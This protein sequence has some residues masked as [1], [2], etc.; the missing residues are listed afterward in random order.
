MEDFTIPR[1][2]NK[3]YNPS[4]GEDKKDEVKDF[5]CKHFREV[6]DGP[7][8]NKTDGPITKEN[9]SVIK[10]DDLNFKGHIRIQQRAVFSGKIL[11]FG[12]SLCK[13]NLT[14]SPNDLLKH[15]RAVHKGS[16]PTYPCDLCDFVTNE[17]PALQRHRIEHRNTLVT[18]ELCNDHVQYS[19][20]LLTRH[21]MMCHSINGE[22]KCDWCE[23]TTVDAG[24]FVQ[25]IHHHNESHWKCTI[26]RHISLNEEDHQSHIKAHSGTFTF[27]CQICGFGTAECEHLKKHT[28]TVHKEEAARK[29]A[30]KAVEDC[31][32]S[33]NSS[34][35][36][37]LYKK[38][39]VSQETQ[40]MSKL[41][42][43]PGTVSNENGR[44]TK[45]ELPLEEI[46]HL[47]DGTVGQRDNKSWSFHNEE[48]STPVMLQE[49]ENANNSDTGSN[50]STNGLTV[51]MVKNKI[52]LPPNCT[53][54]MMGFKIVDGKKHLV[55]KVIPTAKQDVS[56]QNH[57]LID[58]V[59]S[60]VSNP[61]VAK[62]IDFIEKKQYSECKGS[63]SKCL[64]ISPKNGSCIQMD[65]NDIMA[66][67][68]K[69]EEEETSVCT[70]NSIPHSEQTN[71]LQN[72]SYPVANNS[73]YSHFRSVSTEEG[74]VPNANNSDAG[75]F[76][77][78]GTN[79]GSKVTY[80]KTACEDTI[81]CQPPL[82]AAHKTLFPKTVFRETV[83]CKGATDEL[84]LSDGFGRLWKKCKGKSVTNTLYID[85]SCQI[86]LEN[87]DGTSIENRSKNGL[88]VVKH[89]KSPSQLS[90]NVSL[91]SR[92]DALGAGKCEPKTSNQEVFTFHNYSKEIFRSSPCN[93]QNPPCNREYSG[94]KEKSDSPENTTPI[95]DEEIE[96][97]ECIG[98]SDLLTEENGDSVIQD[99][100]IIKIE[101][102]GIPIS[103]KQTEAKTSLLSMES[104][105]KEH[106]NAII[107]QQLNKERTGFSNPS[108]AFLKQGEKSLNILQ[109]PCA[110]R[111]SLILKAA[112]KACPMPVQ[113]KATPNFK[114]ITSTP[115]SQIRLSKMKQELSNSSNITS[116]TVTPKAKIVG[117][118]ARNPQAT[119]NG[120]TVLSAVHSGGGT[121]SNHYIINS[122]GFKGPVLLSRTLH[123]TPT[124]TVVKAKPTCYFV[125]RSVPFVQNPS[126]S[127]FKL[128]GPQL[129]VISQPV[130]AGTFAEKASTPQTSRQAYLL[131]Y[132]SPSKSGLLENKQ[133][134]KNQT[135]WSQTSEYSGNKVIFKFISPTAHLNSAVAPTSSNQP[136]ILATRPQGQCF[137]VS[138]NKTN[139]TSCE[140]K[141][142]LCVQNDQQKHQKEPSVS[143][144]QINGDLQ[145][146]ETNSLLLAPRRIRQR[147]RHR[148]ALFD[149]LPAALHK[150]RRLSNKELTDKETVLWTPVGK[151]VERTLRLAP[152]S[153]AQQIKY[154]CRYQPVVVL[155]HP[156]AD[157]PEVTNIMKAVNRY[158]GAITKV[159]LSQKTVQALSEFSDLVN[160]CSPSNGDFS[161]PRPVLSSVRERF[162]LKLKLR[163][164]NR[165][166]YE[167]V[168][169]L[170]VCGQNSVVFDC[171]FCGR[172]F[173]NQ[174]DWIGHG[175]RH[176]MEATRDWHKLS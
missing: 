134:A 142:L 116:V 165:K 133:E 111:P 52:S 27:T 158:K 7:F 124:N 69:I 18:C 174:E 160:N 154:P 10:K 84:S 49:C 13:N 115:N 110:G 59:G 138:T 24:T 113:V 155:N 175:Q 107:T 159:A 162:L 64:A 6:N 72:R 143:Q 100:N 75:S 164:K 137:L 2:P 5:V 118:A 171:W 12:C 112:E 40:G 66:V 114:L 3:N 51:L 106:S 102:D 176:L 109:L 108:N 9:G 71:L 68:V 55:L 1:D 43:P 37:K 21:Y 141:K 26:C 153:T 83:E 121:S 20:L 89:S 98:N 73:T 156:D 19:L 41:I 95:T 65:R 46:H 25:H 28:S 131:R 126:T 17:F 74:D 35:N 166:K 61:V 4:A 151:E 62:R 8:F 130:L 127:S 132:I 67:K 14:F 23:F 60:V 135:I 117:V 99:L 58:G 104:F 123:G 79:Y 47:I 80:A 82:I 119:E 139:P 161:T 76:K 94:H 163:K 57:S 92:V 157:I 36:M 70:V 145:A 48:H 11:S 97:D 50:P 172:L 144:L 33:A 16:L 31:S 101:E 167:V 87:N 53:T 147:K 44:V 146:C 54:K 125:Q 96:V 173:N 150:V 85:S 30:L 148:K 32:S 81:T 128:P 56:S 22:F 38:I 45:Q 120:T 140:V 170:S 168:K 88:Q 34:T 39:S 152:F 129:P 105:V 86:S 136:L 90:Q 169:T 77:C 122:P 91:S 29:N 103:S 63:T 78:D 42:S 15:F 93:S 149:D